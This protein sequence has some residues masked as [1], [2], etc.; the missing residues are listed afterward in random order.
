MVEKERGIGPD[1]EKM[2][3]GSQLDHVTLPGDRQSH[4][5]SASD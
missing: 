2:A 5:I 1:I 3:W 4:R